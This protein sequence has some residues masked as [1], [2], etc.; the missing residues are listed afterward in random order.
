MDAPAMT[1]VELFVRLPTPGSVVIFT[2]SSV[3]AGESSGSVK[4]KFAALNVSTLSSLVATVA[5]VPAGASFT[6]VTVT[7]RVFVP[8]LLAAWPSFAVKVMVR[9][10]V[11]GASL[12]FA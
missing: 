5:L 1:A 3:L 7:V 8:R 4:P 9:I 2:A 6:A 12:V 10:A 11:D